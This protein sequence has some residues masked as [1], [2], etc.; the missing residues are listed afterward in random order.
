MFQDALI[1]ALRVRQVM[2]RE[3]AE[4]HAFAQRVD[5]HAGRGRLEI[6]VLGFRAIGDFIPETRGGILILCDRGRESG[7][8]RDQGGA[9]R[10]AVGQI[11]NRVHQGHHVPAHSAAPEDGGIAGGFVGPNQLLRFI[12]AVIQ[13]AGLGIAQMRFADDKLFYDVVERLGLGERGGVFG[14]ERLGHV[15][16]VEPHLLR[17]FS[18]VPESAGGRARVIDQL[19]AQERRGLV[20]LRVLRHAVKKQQ[21]AAEQNIVERIFVRFV[22]RDGT[23]RSDE[24]IHGLL[25]VIVVVAIGR[26]V[27]DGVHSFEQSA[28]FVVPHP[29]CAGRGEAA[30]CPSLDRGVRHLL[31]PRQFLRAQRL[32]ER[33]QQRERQK[34]Q[35]NTDARSACNGMK[36]VQEESKKTTRF[37]CSSCLLSLGKGHGPGRARRP[38]KVVSKNSRRCLDSCGGAISRCE[39]RRATSARGLCGAYA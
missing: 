19:L 28:E 37:G 9:A 38:S 4:A 27:P 22:S 30:R 13:Q 2:R 14:V 12:P 7:K 33:S 39:T 1:S 20:I 25:H 15:E 17:I 34:S 16:A 26:V 29:V 36:I 31:R 18:F 8:N 21:L 5:E 11:L 23:V 10:I 3:V 6:I 35:E 24:L 32:R